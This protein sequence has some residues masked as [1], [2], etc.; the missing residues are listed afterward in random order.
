MLTSS[1]GSEPSWEHKDWQNGAFTEV[2][3]Q[4]LEDSDRD[5]NG[6]ISMGELTRHVSQGVPRLVRKIDPE[7][8]QTPGMEMRFER[9]IFAAGL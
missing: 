2:L 9:T 5:R 8:R 1:D 6:V 7:R 4:A 3:L